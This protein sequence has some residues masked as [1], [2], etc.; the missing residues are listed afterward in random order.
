ML[1][2][3]I[4][5]LVLPTLTRKV[6]CGSKVRLLMKAIGRVFDHLMPCR[7]S[8]SGGS[9]LE[10]YYNTLQYLLTHGAPLEGIGFQSHFGRKTAPALGRSRAVEIQAR[11]GG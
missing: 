6:S 8:L 1:R 5:R 11:I 9:H 3:R 7:T 10:S 2:Q 4:V